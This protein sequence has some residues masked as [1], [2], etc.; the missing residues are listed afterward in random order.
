M[1]TSVLGYWLLSGFSCYVPLPSDN[2]PNV[3]AG[4]CRLQM[5]FIRGVVLYF[6][7]FLFVLVFVCCKTTNN[8]FKRDNISELIMFS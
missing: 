1:D 8:M 7:G 6:L 3:S 4:R 5:P 2:N